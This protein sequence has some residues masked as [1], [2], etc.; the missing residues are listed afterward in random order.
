MAHSDPKELL[1]KLDRARE[2]V[3][4]GGLYRHRDGGSLYRVNSIEIREEDLLPSVHYQAVE[5][6][7]IQW[8]RKL[9]V[10]LERFHRVDFVHGVPDDAGRREG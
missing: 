8:N 9:T 2:M 7:P 10:F 1:Q 3:Q 4:V 5:G 6:A